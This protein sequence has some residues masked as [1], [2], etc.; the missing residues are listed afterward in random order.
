VVDD[1]VDAVLVALIFKASPRLL[2]VF[3]VYIIPQNDRYSKG[4][5]GGKSAEAEEKPAYPHG[6]KPGGLRRVQESVN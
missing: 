1:K 6:L 4:L 5:R 2:V 3:H